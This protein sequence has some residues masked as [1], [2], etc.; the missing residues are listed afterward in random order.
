MS[1]STQATSVLSDT[2][3]KLRLEEEVVDADVSVPADDQDVSYKSPFTGPPPI[4]RP[5]VEADALLDIKPIQ[6]ALEL[7]LASKMVESEEYCLESDKEMER[8][9]FATGYGLIQCVKGMMSY[10]DPD[11]LAGISHT[12]HGNV[13]ANAHR[14]KGGGGVVGG[15]GRI[16][17]YVLPSLSPTAH[18]EAMTPVERH[19]ELVYAESLFEKALLGIVYSGDWL[20][21]IK[22]A[23]NMRTTISIY[24]RLYEFIEA[25]DEKYRLSAQ[26]AS[27]PTSPSSESAPT[28]DPSIDAHFRSG[29]YLGVGLSNIILSLMPSKILSIVELFGYKGDRKFGLHVLMKTGGW[30]KGVSEPS[31][32]AADEGARRTI[33][34][35]ALLIFHLVLS[36]FTFECIDVSIAQTILEWNLKRY[37][38][39]VFFLFGAGRLA[40][41]RSQPAQA[42]EYYTK[43]MHS[44]Q[45]Y[46]NL[47]H[48]SFWE[49][50]VAHLALW[51]VPGSLE[52]WQTLVK[53][54][55]WSKSIYSYG[56]AVCLL[57]LAIQ[58]G[59]EEKKKEAVKLMAQVPELRQ[60]IAG[61]SI[62]LEVR[63]FFY[64]WKFV[65]RKARKFQSQG[66]RLLL[67]ALELT[68]IFLGI[69]HAPREIIKDKMLVDVQNVVRHLEED[70]DGVVAPPSV[71]SSSAPVSPVS[72]PTTPKSP[73]LAKLAKLGGGSSPLLSSGSNGEK[74]RKRKKLSQYEGGEAEFWDDYC[75]AKFLEGVCLRYIAYPD[76]D[77]A[78][79]PQDLESI[80][81]DRL[82]TSQAA[83]QA[84]E[85]I[86]HNGLK[87]SLDH[88][89]V[90]H[91]HYE[92]GRLLAC[93]GDEQGAQTHF[94]LVLSGKTLTTRN[95]KYSM[96]NA[97]HVRTHAALEALNSQHKR[98]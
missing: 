82:A 60:R 44:Q 72:T 68:Y 14:A 74:Q 78:L 36:S 64:F 69:A 21:F 20:A 73:I 80:K 39:G 49:M 33:C 29:V 24:R 63:I 37:P 46:R 23:L 47:H 94:D 84:F 22:E 27:S 30:T 9:Y 17:G 10:E 34:D 67:P 3:E 50:S 41:V 5:Y 35:M 89:I 87:I 38:N 62:P 19:A 95:G 26:E 16:F 18:I 81:A 6:Y 12:R 53:E 1:I 90:Y 32:S 75:L 97:L 40:L 91:A 13:I 25:A 43:A 66:N 42:I 71:W 58:D 65:A 11:L 31:V 57:Q 70:F 52:C 77:A 7:F 28:E 79:S 76:P 51:D 55:T 4:Q 45:Q 98:L 15:V 92:L 54:A 59:D 48:I 56:T 86:F 85:T 8:L 88:H 96:E 61:K 2:I 83:I 93:Q